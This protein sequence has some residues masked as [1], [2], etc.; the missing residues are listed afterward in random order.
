MKKEA[1]DVLTFF[2]EQQG[3]SNIVAAMV[4]KKSDQFLEH[5]VSKLHI[6]HETRFL[7]GREL[8]TSEIREAVSPYLE[9]LLAE[10]GD[11]LIDMIQHFPHPPPE[12]ESAPWAPSLK[13]DQ[14]QEKL[15]ILT[16]DSI[17]PKAMARVSES[18]RVEDLPPHVIYLIELGL[19]LEKIRAITRKFPSFSYYSLE[20]KIKPLVEFFLELGVPESDIPRVLYR[21]PQLCGISLSENLIQTMKYLEDELG[22][23]KQKWP[24]LIL[25]FPAMFTLSRR[26]INSA[27]SFLTEMGISKK[28]IGKVLTRCPNILGCS[29]EDNLR[30]T[31]KY[32]SSMGAD[33]TVIVQRCPQILTLS[34]ESNLRTMTEFFLE[35]GYSMKEIAMMIQ[36]SPL[37]Y[38]FSLSKNVLPKWEFFVSMGYARSELVKFPHYFSLSLE[39]RIKPRYALMKAC[40]LRWSLGYLLTLTDIRFDKIMKAKMEMMESSYC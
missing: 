39:R 13:L 21:S 32:F 16:I 27:V 4:V 2:L 15:P 17:R 33:V 22:I 18:V 14:D 11:A 30:P 23:D 40:G 12:V 6:L 34:I 7:A 9:A 36:R 19:D 35:K 37:L 1:K 24:K 38:T 8:T 29:L 10:H 25:R 5:L 3:L 28:T 26:K 20:R 31:A